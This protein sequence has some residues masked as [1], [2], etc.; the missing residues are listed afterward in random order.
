L[1]RRRPARLSSPR[2]GFAGFWY[3][4]EV[5]TLAVRHWAVRWYLRFGLSY[6]D[7]EELLEE[8]GIGVDQVKPRSY[9]MRCPGK[10][11]PTGHSRDS[12]VLLR[13]T[14]RARRAVLGVLATTGGPGRW[15]LYL[16]RWGR[17][18]SLPG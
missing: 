14:P 18:G 11:V 8:R 10:T 4:P 6:C 15:G 16:P 12:A 13:S 3:S 9:G 5:I 1:M 17:G 7:V 2:S